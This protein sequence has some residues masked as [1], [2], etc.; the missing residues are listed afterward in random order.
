MSIKANIVGDSG[1]SV[2]VYGEGYITTAVHQHPPENETIIALP[3]RQYFTD[4]GMT[5]GDF[6]MRVD[7]S[8]N[9][10]IFSVTADSEYD[11][12]IK[13]IS[14]EISDAG[15][16]LNEFGSI[17]ALTNGVGFC[18]TTQ[19]LGNY[20]IA[21][22]LKTN[23]N[24]VRLCAGEPSFGT[25]TSAFRA[26]NVSGNSEG[27]IPVFDTSSLFGIPWGLRLRKG[28]KDRIEFIIRDNLTGVDS[29][30]AVAFGT[31]I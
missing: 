5:S 10:V 24:F 7:G 9:E 27:F 1:R 29:F 18:W 31:R 26:N 4:N 2:E 28:T 20:I 15:A 22:S 13:K 11:I 14:F 3:F 12:Y 19:A 17:G 21:E 6:D 23:W 25:G 16:N 30:N 8:T